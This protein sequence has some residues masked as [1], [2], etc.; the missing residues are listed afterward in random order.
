VSTA[1]ELQKLAQLRDQGVLTEA[2]FQS[3]KSRLLGQPAD[4]QISPG[5]DPAYSMPPSH[6]PPPPPPSYS[7][8]PVAPSLSS[9]RR[10]WTIGVVA[11]CVVAFVVGLVVATTG[12][13]HRDVVATFVAAEPQTSQSALNSTADVIS[14]RLSALGGHAHAEVKNRTIVI[15][16]NRPLSETIVA[17]VSQVGSLFLRPVFCYAPPFVGTSNGSALS[18][19]TTLPKCSATSQLTATN[20]DINANTGEPSNS[21][22]ED[23]SLADYP[24]TAPADDLE[25]STVLLPG[26]AGDNQRYLLGP[27]GLTG[28]SVHSAVAQQNATGQWVV[29][30]Q[31]TASGSQAWDNF[32]QQNFHELVAI[33]LDG[34]VQSAPIIQPSQSTFTTFDGSGTISGGANF[35]EAYAKNLALAMEFGSLPVL[36]RRT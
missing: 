14:S 1:D 12:S 23:L 8:P 34:V 6:S 16:S 18:S 2:E 35:T 24:S 33:E 7:P 15:L 30:Y 32:A 4:F 28:R 31:L 11:V 17:A 13:A 10:V 29:N 21:V 26:I 19:T 5:A 27:A 25:P 3:L 36:L 22:P 20:L 9:N